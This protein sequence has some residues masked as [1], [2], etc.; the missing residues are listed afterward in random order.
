MQVL[1]ECLRLH[2]PLPI[3]AK[4]AGKDVTLLD[5]KLPKGTPL[6]VCVINNY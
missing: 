4:Q 5:T 2:P 3:I 1:E 6:V